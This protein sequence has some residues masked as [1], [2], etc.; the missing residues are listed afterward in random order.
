L[1]KGFRYVAKCARIEKKVRD[2]IN[3]IDSISCHQG[4]EEFDLLVLVDE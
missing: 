1:F 4:Q 2:N 3:T